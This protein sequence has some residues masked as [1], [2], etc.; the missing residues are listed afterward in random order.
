MAEERGIPRMTD[1]KTNKPRPST[2]MIKP[3]FLFFIFFYFGIFLDL[4]EAHDLASVN[5]N[6]WLMAVGVSRVTCTG[7]WQTG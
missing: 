3:L 7:C 1:G 6:V 2:G 4:T 5:K